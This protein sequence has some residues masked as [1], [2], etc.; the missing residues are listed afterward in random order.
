MS[1][2]RDRN[3]VWAYLDQHGEILPVLVEA[4]LAMARSSKRHF[5]AGKSPERRAVCTDFNL[6]IE[7]V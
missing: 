7:F 5:G 6:D 2:F 4:C 3:K 1:G